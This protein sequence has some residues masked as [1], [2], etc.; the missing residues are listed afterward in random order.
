MTRYHIRLNFVYRATKLL[1]VRILQCGGNLCNFH[2]HC[3]HLIKKVNLLQSEGNLYKFVNLFETSAM[4]LRQKDPPFVNLL[5]CTMRTLSS[6]NSSGLFALRHILKNLKKYTI[7]HIFF[8]VQTTW[9][10]IEK[11]RFSWISHSKFS[12][13]VQNWAVYDTQTSKMPRYS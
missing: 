6:S 9:R 11:I 3:S 7:E 4:L 1:N 10:K 8:L 5:Q 12:N 2:T 13:F